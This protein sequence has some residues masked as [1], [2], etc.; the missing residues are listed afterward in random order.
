[1]ELTQAGRYELRSLLGKGGGG[2]VYAGWDP[3][4]G[5]EVAVKLV[6]LGEIAGQDAMAWALREARAAG[7]LSHPHIVTV[8]DIGALEGYAYIVMELVR[9][10]NLA[11]LLKQD[12]PAARHVLGV[13]RQAAEALDFAHS[14][15]IV[16]RDVKPA[17]ILIRE[18]GCA[19]IGDFGIA[20][21]QSAAKLT[22]TGQFFGTPQ[23]MSPEQ[24]QGQAV[25]GR[26]DQF[27]LAVVAY[28]ALAG[29]SPYTEEGLVFQILTA[30][31]PPVDARWDPVFRKGLAKK[32]EERY[33]SC[34]ALVEALEQA[35][36]PAPAPVRAS[37]ASEPRKALAAAGIA[38]LLALAVGGAWWLARPRPHPDAGAAPSAVRAG[39][40][41]AAEPAPAASAVAPAST[42]KPNRETPPRPSATPPELK[43][44]AGAEP[45]NASPPPP[46]PEA[47]VPARTA[48]WSGSLAPGA[49]L[50][51]GA[52]GPSAGALTVELPSAFLVDRVTPKVAEV[53]ESPSAANGW[54][55]LRIRNSGSQT[56]DLVTIRFRPRP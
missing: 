48:I 49:E 20:R 30:P 2:A 8:H 36:A 54:S 43:P 37:P 25:D 5:R 47:D 39:E 1:M 28:E 33:S 10:T 16:H 52:A 24:I 9:G 6:P 21:I 14:R 12:P 44:S 22:R 35:F 18:D 13:L 27:S 53:V 4:I 41:P 50:T 45:K 40:P 51:F 55:Q 11:A 23:Y 3:L 42:P 29:R 19:K 15:G 26:S 34:T 31:P 17:N 7:V 56:L 32:P 38:A 46:S